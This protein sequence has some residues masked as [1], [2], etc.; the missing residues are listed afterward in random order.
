MDAIAPGSYTS[1]TKRLLIDFADA[2]FD[3]VDNLE[4]LSW[5][6]TLPNGNR[7]LV[8][9]SDNNFNETQETQFYVYEVQP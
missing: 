3:H 9:V 8:I 1:A 5:G 2:G 4:G 7:T 6:P